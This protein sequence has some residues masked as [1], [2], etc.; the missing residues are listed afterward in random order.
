MASA[1]IAKNGISVAM[2]TD[3]IIKTYKDHVEAVKN[4][5]PAGRLLVFEVK[6]GWGPLCKFLGLPVPDT[7]F[8]RSNNQKDFWDRINNVPQ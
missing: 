4:A 6:E 3:A 7:D 8:P 1:V 5:V 2:T